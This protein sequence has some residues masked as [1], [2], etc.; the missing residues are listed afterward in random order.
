M[1]FN[2]IRRKAKE[3]QIKSHRMN[4]K[5]LIRAIQRA[6]SNIECYATPRVEVCSEDSCL[7][8]NDCR[9]NGHP[10]MQ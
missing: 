10:A 3:M 9:S 6:E 2:D 1:K 7:W 5:D 8:R 4:K